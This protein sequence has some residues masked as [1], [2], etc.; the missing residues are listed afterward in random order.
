MTLPEVVLWQALRK[1]RIAG[2]R[3]RR[4]MPVG[5]FITDFGCAEIKLII[6]VD[7]SSH[8][9]AKKVIRDEQR[10]AYLRNRGYTVFRIAARDV[11]QDLNAV[12]EGIEAFIAAGLR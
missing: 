9:G 5:P 12:L 4:Q 2:R 8:D 7:G 11:L 1:G 6:E 3:F 10:S